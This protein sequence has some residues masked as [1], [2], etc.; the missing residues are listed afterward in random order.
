MI[1]IAPNYI[2]D[3]ITDRVNLII[4]NSN[5][6]KSLKFDVFIDENDTVYLSTK[7]VANFFDGNIYYDNNTMHP[8][9]IGGHDGVYIDYSTDANVV[10]SVIWDNGD[11]IMQLEG[12]L[13]KEEIIALAES[14]KIKE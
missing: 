3:E 6:T 7:D 11:Y 1:N 4:N 2:R 12:V 13:T 5:I 14:V 9:N 8:I 10:S